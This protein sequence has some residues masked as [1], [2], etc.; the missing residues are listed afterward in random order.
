M[1]TYKVSDVDY[2]VEAQMSDSLMTTF[3]LMWD[4]ATVDDIK[5]ALRSLAEDQLNN[6]L[7]V[8]GEEFALLVRE[9]R[10]KRLWDELVERGE[11]SDE[12]WA[13][14]DQCL[15]RGSHD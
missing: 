15:P 12:A 2:A 1:R 13:Y 3:K 10:R 11:S 7:A 9:L 4:G 8:G 6:D 14:V 5:H